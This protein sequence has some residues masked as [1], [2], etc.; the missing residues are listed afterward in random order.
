MA[1][2]TGGGEE[3]RNKEN[4]SSLFPCGGR[5]REDT[6]N[7]ALLRKCVAISNV[8]LLFKYSIVSM[9]SYQL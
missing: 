2:A 4:L 5:G 1:L 9:Q 3:K 8:V 7:L 6:V